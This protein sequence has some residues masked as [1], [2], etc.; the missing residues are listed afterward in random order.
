ML[1]FNFK[2]FDVMC[3]ISLCDSLVGNSFFL[4]KIAFLLYLFYN[5]C[6]DIANEYWELKFYK[7]NRWS[8]D[9]D[10]KFS[11]TTFSDDGPSEFSVQGNWVRVFIGRPMI[12]IGYSS[13]MI[14]G[15]LFWFV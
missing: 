13:L 1:F 3:E 8:F 12:M 15:S 5:L 10:N 7:N 14:F 2:G 9:E 4:L 6:I 11:G